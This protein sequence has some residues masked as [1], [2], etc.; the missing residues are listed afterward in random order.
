LRTRSHLAEWRRLLD[1]VLEAWP[2]GELRTARADVLGV[3]AEL[4]AWHTDYNRAR[5]LTE[6]QVA[7]LDQVGDNARLASA[8]STMA[9]G[10]LMERPEAAVALFERSLAKSAEAGDDTSR[11]GAL[12][13]LAIAQLRL[14]KLDDARSTALAAIQV[15]N[16][17]G[18][19]Y[20]NLF[21]VMTLGMIALRK[22]DRP[23]SARLFADALRRAHSAGA[24]IGI[25]VTVD[26]IAML[27][28]ED[29]NVGVAARLA[30]A[31]DRLRQDGGGAPTLE[32][33]GD[34]NII[35]Q[36]RDADPA[37]LEAARASIGDFTTEDAIAA[38]FS[39]ADAIES[40]R[41]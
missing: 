4:A 15:G 31:A 1:R 23:E 36:V 19:Q 12:Q 5:Q 9:W 6:E 32:L 37:A 8:F 38:A 20:T 7:L 18:D 14:N 41:A 21:N 26:A 25:A 35:D 30:L 27:T 16:E 24:S 10:N 2:Q 29:G 39:A 13:G 22:G 17:T 3:A 28:L 11:I 34:R 40:T 33:V